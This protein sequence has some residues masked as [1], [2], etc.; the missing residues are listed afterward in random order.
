MVHASGVLPFTN[1]K[2]GQ[3]KLGNWITLE[4]EK[5]IIPIK[6]KN[7]VTLHLFFL[8]Q[9]SMVIPIKYTLPYYIS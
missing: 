9:W 3:I 8:S 1:I 7:F 2:N 4:T 6:Y 5:K